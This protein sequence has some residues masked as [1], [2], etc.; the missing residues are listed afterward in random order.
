[1]NPQIKRLAIQGHYGAFHEIAAK[2]FYG[3]KKIKIQ[4]MESFTELI[5]AIEANKQVDQG[6]MA[7]ENSIAGSLLQNY[8]LLN[9][10]K[11]H[12]AGEVFLRISQNLMVLPKQKIENIT[13]VYSHPIAIAQCKAFFRQYPQIKL[14]ESSDTA[15]SAKMIQDKNMYHAGAIASS[16]AAS[17][18]QMEIIATSIE[19]HKSNYTRFLVINPGESTS[20]STEARKI[21]VCFSLKHEIGSLHKIL[22]S[23]LHHKANLTKIQ[24]VPLLGSPWEYLFFVDMVLEDSTDYKIILADL[25]QQTIKLKLLG[26]YKTGNYYES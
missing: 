6:L 5:E 24:S 2:H 18:Y 26:K 19:T 9:N 21:S 22:G 17:L 25:K 16:L 11:V 8:Q 23:L 15:L 12:I 4:P 20:N 14:I 7:I 13:E 3:T 1:M 10:A